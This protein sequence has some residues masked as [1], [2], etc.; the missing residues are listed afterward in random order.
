MPRQH[1]NYLINISKAMAKSKRNAIVGTVVLR[2]K[3]H[4]DFE[5][6]PLDQAGDGVSH[7]PYAP[8]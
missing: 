1:K 7:P 2:F 4:F 3:S 8:P 6:R 5:A